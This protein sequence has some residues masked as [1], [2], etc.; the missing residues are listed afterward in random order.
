M[1]P[2][3]AAALAA[4]VIVG[5]VLVYAGAAKAAA[6]SEEFANIILAYNLIPPDMALPLAAFLPWIELAVGWSILLGVETKLVSIAA[7]TLFAT[8]LLALGH[9]L[10]ESIPLPSC[11]CFGDAIHLTLGQGLAF[12][13]TLLAFS[14]LIWWSGP[15]SFSLDAWTEKGA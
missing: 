5:A 7:G 6:P 12:D 8:F 9:A 14:V 10:A 13:S 11:G 1:K 3:E 4:R 15:G 2:R